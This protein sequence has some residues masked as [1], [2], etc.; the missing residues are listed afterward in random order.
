MKQEIYNYA[1]VPYEV[2]QRMSLSN[3]RKRV[4]DGMVIINQ[5]DM[6]GL[7]GE[8]LQEKVLNVGGSLLTE[9]QA[10]EEL[11]SGYVITSDEVIQDNEVNQDDK[12]NFGEDGFEDY[13]DDKDA[14]VKE[15]PELTENQEKE[16]EDE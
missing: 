13:A 14:I 2:A 9:I 5:S 10:I 16:E 15:L 8:T 7:E 1:K 12:D 11:K 4:A 3:I 6:V